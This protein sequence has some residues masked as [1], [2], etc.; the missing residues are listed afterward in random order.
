MV[1]PGFE[2][3]EREAVRRKLVWG[4][5]LQMGHGWWGEAGIVEVEALPPRWL[6]HLLT[7]DPVLGRRAAA[8]TSPWPTAWTGGGC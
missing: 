3:L 8:G 4:S 7:G 1:F 5:E 6:P 2:L